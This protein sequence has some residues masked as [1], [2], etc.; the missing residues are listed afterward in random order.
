[1]C[2]YHKASLGCF[3][4]LDD[5]H[6]DGLVPVRTMGDDFYVYEPES[7]R[8]VGERRHRVFQLGDRLEVVLAGVAPRHRGLDLTIAGMPAAPERAP[9]GRGRRPA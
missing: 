5:F 1:M 8:L 6:V 4:Q 2:I 3:V 9:G 7:H